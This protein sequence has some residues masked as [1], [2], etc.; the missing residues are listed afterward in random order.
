MSRLFETFWKNHS[1]LNNKMSSLLTEVSKCLDE[2]RLEFDNIIK[3]VTEHDLNR[4]SKSYEGMLNVMLGCKDMVLLY[5]RN[6]QQYQNAYQN[7]NK[8]LGKDEQKNW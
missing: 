6:F 7:F 4:L 1:Q 8:Q 3:A 5:S 2:Q